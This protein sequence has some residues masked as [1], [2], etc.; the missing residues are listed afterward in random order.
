M[1]LRITCLA[2]AAAAVAGVLLPEGPAAAQPGQGA[3]RGRAI[4]YL[5]D[6]EDFVIRNGTRRFNRALYGTHTAFRVEAGDLP[7]FAL[8][9]PGVGGNLQLGLVSGTQSK[10]LIHAEAI[11]ARYRPGMMLYRIEDAMLGDAVLDLQV[12]ALADTEGLVLKAA[13]TGNVP[14]GVQ[15][16]SVFGGASGKKFSRAGDIGA[17]PE[18]GFYLHPEYCVGNTYQLQGHRFVLDYTQGRDGQRRLT[19][20]FPEGGVLRLGDAH[21]LTSPHALL[22]SSA[23]AAPVVYAVLDAA[24]GVSRYWMVRT[25]GLQE[26]PDMDAAEAFR[27]AEAARA[28]LAGTVKLHT[29]DPFINTLGGAL[30]VAADAIW[31]D[32]TFLH[33]AV[34]WRMR[35]NAWRGAYA[36]DLLGWSDRARRHFESYARSQVLTPESAPVVMDTALHLARHLEEMGTAMFSSGYISRNPNDNTRPHHYDM[37]LVFFDQLLNH[38]DWTGDTAFVRE[39]WPYIKRHLAWE[40]RNFDSDGDGLY[41]AYCAIW[42]SD[43]L[44]YSGGGV[45][46]TSAYNY[47]ANRVAA[48]L[49]QLV[50]DDPAPYDKE[51]QKIIKAMNSRLWLADKG[52]YAE[53]ED[54]LGNRLLHKQPG[55][56]TIYHA[57]DAGTADPFMAYQSLRYIDT[58][59]PHIPV[60]ARGLEDTTLYTLSTT[61]WQ[62]YTWSVNN[63]ALAEVLNTA[64]AYWQGGRPQEAFRLW[65]SSLMESMYLGASPGNFQQLSYHDARRGELYRDFAD[66]IGVAARTVVEGLF[67]IRPRA[68]DGVLHV[69]PGL[70]AEWTFASF[71]TPDVRFD[72][73]R[74]D[75]TEHY[76]LTPR[77]QTA[78]RLVM[79]L[80]AR[81]AGIRSVTIN[82]V[83]VPWRADDNAVGTPAIVLEAPA[84]P[85]YNIVVA[86]DTAPI[87]RLDIAGTCVAGTALTLET[88]RAAFM[89]Y[90]DP[91][92][93]LTAVARQ[94]HRLTATVG[95]EAGHGTFFVQL[96]QGAFTWWQPVDVERVSRV[97]VSTDIARGEQATGLTLHNRGAAMRVRLLLNG[98]PPGGQ[99]AIDLPGNGTAHVALPAT[100]LVFG[101]NRIAVLDEHDSLLVQADIP[102]W[103]AEP[104]APKTYDM[105]P[106]DSWMNARVDEI[107]EQRYLSPRPVSPTLQLPWQGIGNWCYPLTEAHIDDSGLRSKAGTGNA[108]A[109]PGGI[110]MR[111][112][113]ETEAPNVLFVSMW[114]NYPDEASIPLA[115][116]ASH[117][118]LL[119]AGST[120][121]MQSHVTNGEVVITY[122]DG[123]M[124]RLELRN[125]DNWWPIE[126]DYYLDSPAFCTGKPHPYRIHLKTGEIHRE[127]PRYTEI[128]GFT[129][130]AVDGGAAT[131]LDV[132]LDKSKP[133]KSLQLRAVANDVVIGLMGATLC[134]D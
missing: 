125:P 65:R 42:A 85:A 77:F 86:W 123:T 54:L 106:M 74:K 82:G 121:P 34:A 35:L 99:H 115:G 79:R 95:P 126:Q 39:M 120:N 55:V 91:Q 49:A 20:S 113:G 5:P 131:L 17:D 133:L 127:S 100:Q 80:P 22:A 66:P 11:E 83:A 68:L 71:E 78:M 15:L 26:N 134:R 132:P 109:L 105:V 67:G 53:Y 13:V 1:R 119:M 124:E 122:A 62:P 46:H 88:R 38:F 25:G 59:I 36:G 3:D 16:V 116:H 101:T 23:S 8:Y 18:S 98:Q 102:H 28:A 32:P 37:N 81:A 52:W 118:Y 114:D 108:I 63:V 19:G 12:L 50:G 33:G 96:R 40:K 107:F 103:D 27:R 104:A 43:G 21:A 24:P 112:T 9:L 41:D 29:P 110:P 84:A 72:Y 14:E 30:A 7:E 31:E 87:E 94:P 117:A 97:Q 61:N 58:Q 44:Q 56:W 64:L 10:W 128:K 129:Q 73:Q 48:R 90:R 70:P 89:D 45:T 51:A 130:R 6:G 47:R 92:G 69:G 4:R 60:R 93:S 57:L 111:T 76:L 2:M 75:S